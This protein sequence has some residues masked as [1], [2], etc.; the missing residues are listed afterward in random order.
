MTWTILFN[1]VAVYRVLIEAQYVVADFTRSM[2]DQQCT[3]S[4]SMLII[5]T[6]FVGKLSI[7]IV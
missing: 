7:T 1:I 4:R 5:M 2:V 6:F 3:R